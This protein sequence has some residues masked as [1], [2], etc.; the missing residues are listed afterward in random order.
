MSNSSILL[1]LAGHCPP[2]PRCR[3]GPRISAPAAPCVVRFPNC[4]ECH[5]LSG[6]PDYSMRCLGA[7]V[8]PLSMIGL[9]P[10]G[11]PAILEIGF[12]WFF[13]KLCIFGQQLR[14]HTTA[15]C[16]LFNQAKKRESLVRCEHLPK[17]RYLPVF[18]LG[19]LI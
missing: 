6:E 19:V 12:L 11:A 8:P 10:T 1:V 3:K 5:F 9:P 14:S 15:G 18:L 7:L 17:V 2:G 4:H 13:T 16:R